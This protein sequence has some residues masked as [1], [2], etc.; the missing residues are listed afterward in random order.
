MFAHIVTVMID[1]PKTPNLQ[2][3]FAPVLKYVVK[4]MRMKSIPEKV[5]RE[6]IVAIA[7]DMMEYGRRRKTPEAFLSLSTG[8]VL[9]DYGLHSAEINRYTRDSAVDNAMKQ[10][11]E[12]LNIPY[13]DA[14]LAVPTPADLS[15]IPVRSPHHAASELVNI[16]RRENWGSGKLYWASGIEMSDKTAQALL[17][18]RADIDDKF[19]IT[20]KE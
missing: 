16:A 2:S 8:T 20:F 17:D 13:T 19:N 10:L 18:G 11:A 6:T 3:R 14:E 12:E 5:M 15:S 7:D 4:N 9:R 1:K